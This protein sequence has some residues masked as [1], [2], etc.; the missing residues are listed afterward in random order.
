MN[1]NRWFRKVEESLDLDRDPI[2]KF[3][4]DPSLESHKKVLDD[5]RKTLTEMTD[6]CFRT[7]ITNIQANN[8]HDEM[9]CVDGCVRDNVQAVKLLVLEATKNVN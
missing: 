6:L 8:S 1:S 4:F 5:V 3:V 9:K 7:C 2:D